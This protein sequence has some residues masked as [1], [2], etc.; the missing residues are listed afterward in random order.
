MI[1]SYYPSPTAPG[2]KGHLDQIRIYNQPLALG[3]ILKLFQEEGLV[4]YYQFENNPASV[5]R[6]RSGW[7]HHATVSGLVST[8]TTGYLSPGALDFFGGHATLPSS[9]T[10]NSLE[11]YDYTL[12]LR[13]RPDSFPPGYPNQLNSGLLNK[14]A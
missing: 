13:V 2:W 5:V 10:L 1:G 8:N 12:L 9:A 3:E 14:G 11:L 4:A 7:R 6:D